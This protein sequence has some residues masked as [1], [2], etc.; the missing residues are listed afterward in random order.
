M[1]ATSGE[2][3]EGGSRAFLGVSGRGDVP[4]HLNQPIPHVQCVMRQGVNPCSCVPFSTRA[5]I[6]WPGGKNR[7]WQQVTLLE[8]QS[9]DH[10][11]GFS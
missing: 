9:K 4:V 10:S 6:Y 5:P 3:A 1:V 11:R 7:L 2:E 8:V